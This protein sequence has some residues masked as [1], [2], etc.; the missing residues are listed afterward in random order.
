MCTSQF[1]NRFVI[2]AA[3]HSGTQ[4]NIGLQRVEASDLTLPTRFSV[5]GK[6]QIATDRTNNAWIWIASASK[7]SLIFAIVVALGFLAFRARPDLPVFQRGGPLCLL[8]KAERLKSAADFRPSYRRELVER[9]LASS[10]GYT[11]I[12]DEIG[13]RRPNTACTNMIV[14]RLAT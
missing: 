8:S 11:D 9:M 10:F 2:A 13:D 3:P 12:S 1:S 7:N 4:R 6:D 5:R 14:D